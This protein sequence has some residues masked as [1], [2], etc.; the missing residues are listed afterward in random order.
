MK[1]YKLLARA[2]NGLYRIR[3]LRDIPEIDVKA[4][5]LG[6]YVESENNLSHDQKGCDRREKDD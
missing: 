5:D 2:E 6:G 3:A 4:G 1:K